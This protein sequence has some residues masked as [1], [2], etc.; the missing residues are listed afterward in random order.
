MSTGDRWELPNGQHAIEMPGAAG[1]L[2]RVAP[3]VEGWPWPAPPV[4]T[5]RSLCVAQPS[6]YLHGAVPV[7]PEG[8]A[9]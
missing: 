6:R 2:M 1:G 3:I 8:G 4:V 7:Q 5:V 9:A